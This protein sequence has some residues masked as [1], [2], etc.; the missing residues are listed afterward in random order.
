MLKKVGVSG[1]DVVAGSKFCVAAS[2]LARC[3]MQLR[4]T[5]D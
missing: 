5:M 2:G 1:I 4:G 3:S